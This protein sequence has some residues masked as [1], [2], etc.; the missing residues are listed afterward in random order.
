MSAGELTPNQV[1]DLKRAV[2]NAERASGLHYSAYVG[3]VEGDPR[4][5]ALALHRKLDDPAHSVLVLCDPEQRALEIVTGSEAR[6]VLDDAEVG[7]AAATMQSSFAVGDLSGG[8]VGGIQQLGCAARQPELLHV[9][10]Y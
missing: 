8:L 4:D 5:A 6:R 9:T 2:H 1:D 10:R 3:E 7:L